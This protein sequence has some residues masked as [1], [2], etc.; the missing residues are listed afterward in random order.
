M[1][2]IGFDLIED[3]IRIMEDGS[4]DNIVRDQYHHYDKPYIFFRDVDMEPIV[5]ESERMFVEY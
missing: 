5:L 4:A 2:Q 3:S 1:A